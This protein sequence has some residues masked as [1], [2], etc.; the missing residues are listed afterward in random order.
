VSFQ[1]TFTEKGNGTVLVGKQEYN[2]TVRERVVVDSDV[3][4]LSGPCPDANVTANLGLDANMLQG[5][6]RQENGTHLEYTNATTETRFRLNVTV[7]NFSAPVLI[8]TGNNVTWDRTQLNETHTRYVVDVTASE[9]DH[10]NGA[11]LGSWPT[12]E[13]DTATFHRNATVSLAF[14]PMTYYDGQ[15]E[16]K[17]TMNGTVIATDAQTFGTLQFTP[18]G[19]ST[20]PSLS[21]RVAGLHYKPDGVTVNDGY[22]EAFLPTSLL[23]SWGVSDPS[24]LEA[25]YQ[26]NATSITADSVSGGIYVDIP[27]H[28]STGTVEL[29]PSSDTSD[30]S[31]GSDGPDDDDGLDDGN[32]TEDNSTAENTTD[33]ES[34]G[35]VNSTTDDHDGPTD[36]ESDGN[37]SEADESK[38][39]TAAADRSSDGTSGFGPVTALVALLALTLVGARRQ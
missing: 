8:A 4:C 1:A 36:S 19:D 29:T 33:D 21:L 30:G 23:D 26:N 16:R 14:D 20:D 7:Q 32:T 18:G 35:D 37:T 2:L 39:E 24:T 38:E 10:L 9:Y 6:L 17:E 34:T 13:N 25:A 22:Y 15:P 11:Q 28:Y 3:T 27:I 31:D 12:G 5:E